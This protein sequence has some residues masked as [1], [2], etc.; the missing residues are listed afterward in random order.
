[1]S[2][3]LMDPGGGVRESTHT[4]FAT[5]DYV[6]LGSSPAGGGYVPPDGW[7]VEPEE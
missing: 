3:R 7:C 2:V 1:V 6:L 4:L 5:G